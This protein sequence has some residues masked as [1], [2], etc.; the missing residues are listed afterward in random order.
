VMFSGI[1]TPKSL[2]CIL[3]RSYL[4]DFSSVVYL[5]PQNP[6][7]HSL[8]ILT[9]GWLIDFWFAL[10]FD[11]RLTDPILVWC[12][13]WKYLPDRYL[14][15]WLFWQIFNVFWREVERLI[16][17]CYVFWREVGWWN[18]AFCCAFWQE[19]DWFILILLH[20]AVYF[21]ERLKDWFFSLLCILTRGW[22]IYF[23]VGCLFSL[24]VDWLIFRLL[25][26]TDYFSYYY[27]FWWELDWLFFRLLCIWGEVGWLILIC[28][29]FGWEAA[30]LI[31]GFVVFFDERWADEFVGW[32]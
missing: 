10:Y 9:T 7:F 1:L 4:I 32:C 18:F 14:F 19:A 6:I 11:E 31:F 29:V 5:D 22:P 13:F 8:S 17:V 26:M 3:M 15:C 28:H 12:L 21:D 2:L 27:V 23:L 24:E 16:I 20:F 25:C 30:W